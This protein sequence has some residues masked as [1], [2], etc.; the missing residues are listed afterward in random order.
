MK[1]TEIKEVIEN[2]DSFK[3]LLSES[4]SDRRDETKRQHT[5][6]IGLCFV[7]MFLVIGMVL[8]ALH[9]Q[10]VIHTIERESQERLYEFLSEYDFETEIQLDTNHIVNSD[11]AGNIFFAR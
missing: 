7:I 8:M 10:N 6:I 11:S 4:L 9:N 3:K 5:T 1:E 2:D